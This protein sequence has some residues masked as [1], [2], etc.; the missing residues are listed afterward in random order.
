MLERRELGCCFIAF[1]VVFLI[2]TVCTIFRGCHPILC[3]LLE[4]HY[5]RA[6]NESYFKQ[7]ECT[8]CTKYDDGGI[9]VEES[10]YDCSYWATDLILLDK[11]ESCVIAVQVQQ[12]RFVFIFY[13]PLDQTCVENSSLIQN[14]AIVGMVFSALAAL[15]FLVAAFLCLLK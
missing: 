11:N 6:I 5:A 15:T 3:P 14:L 8:S 2:T 1:T 13:N 12:T 7:K 4:G 10:P 9:C